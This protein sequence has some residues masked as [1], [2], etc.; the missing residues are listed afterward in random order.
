M[1]SNVTG[2]GVEDIFTYKQWLLS[3]DK[4][5]SACPRDQT[6]QPDN[7]TL[8]SID[9]KTKVIQH[10]SRIK[11]DNFT[12]SQQLSDFQ[13]FF[14]MFHFTVHFQVILLKSFECSSDWKSGTPTREQPAGSTDGKG[15]GGG[16]QPAHTQ[17][18]KWNIQGIWGEDGNGQEMSGKGR[19][20]NF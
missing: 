14:I 3:I 4:S 6:W 1:N 7:L 12:G 11:L 17:H 20:G 16:S 8:L 13:K 9:I 5:C 19:G 18:K 2:T 10:V 15:L